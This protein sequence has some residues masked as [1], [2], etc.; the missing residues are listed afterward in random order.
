MRYVH[1][2]LPQSRQMKPPV[3]WPTRD[4]GDT[5]VLRRSILCWFTREKAVKFIVVD[6]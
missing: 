5:Y 1:D 3:R 2:G 4:D 6:L